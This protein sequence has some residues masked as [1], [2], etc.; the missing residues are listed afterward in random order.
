[1]NPGQL[2]LIG[3]LRIYRGVLSPAKAILFG[4]LGRC[5]YFPSCST[6]AIEAVQIHGAVFGSWLAL[7]RVCRCQPWGGCGYDPVPLNACEEGTPRALP[8]GTFV[9]T[10]DDTSIPHCD[11]APD[12]DRSRVAAASHSRKAMDFPMPTAGAL[13]N[14]RRD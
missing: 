12:R 9:G 6:Y 13:E 4:P 1:M 2:I 14:G 5:R 3:A 11:Q 8:I 10:L 7:K